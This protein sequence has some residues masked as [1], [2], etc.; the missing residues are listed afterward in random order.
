MPLKLITIE[1]YPGGEQVQD[2]L[3]D[4]LEIGWEIESITAI[5]GGSIGKD[6]PNPNWAVPSMAVVLY[7]EDEGAFDLLK[8]Q[9]ALDP[10]R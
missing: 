4:Y 8:H 1:L 7:H 9:R 6:Y 3:T 5:P 10:R 2:H